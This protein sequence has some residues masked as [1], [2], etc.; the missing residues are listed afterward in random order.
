ME[1]EL[2][3]DPR[4]TDYLDHIDMDKAMNFYELKK[5]LDGL[6]YDAPEVA[7]QLRK[8]ID[9]EDYQ[10]AILH[11]RRDDIKF[12]FE[13]ERNAKGDFELLFNMANN[14]THTQYFAPDVPAIEVINTINQ[15]KMNDQNLIY[16]QKNLLN[17][18][19]GEKMN[20]E[21]EQQL[22]A[23]KPEFKL[24]TTQEYN[25]QNVDYTLHFKAGDDRYFFNKYDA[26]LQGKE[27]EQTI[28]LNKGYGY[29]AK[30][31]YNLLEER[32]VYKQFTN[33]EQEKYHLWAKINF[34]EMNE[35]GTTHKLDTFSEGWNY[36][37]ERGIDKIDLV[38]MDSAQERE[39]LFKS[40]E[41]GNRHEVT[42]RKDGE[43]VKILLEANPAD[44]RVNVYNAKG[45]QQKLETFKKPELK[46]GKANEQTQQ[47]KEDLPAKKSRKQGAKQ[48]I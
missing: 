25:G 31:A 7:V 42:A 5:A 22:K 39:K 33:L 30:E 21:L 32:S 12:E 20:E 24:E 35:R 36:R 48:H 47:A 15:Q 3:I 37:L 46:A 34:K 44:H 11:I 16:L 27:A 26:A 13:M 45:I 23:G 18:G 4:E 1:D 41:K 19:F 10:H 43:E 14:Q 29:S 9:N 17:L 6:G 8:I 38:G 2:N 40:L 28:F